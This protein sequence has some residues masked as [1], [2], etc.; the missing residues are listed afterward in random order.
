MINLRQKERLKKMTHPDFE[1]MQ[2]DMDPVRSE[3]PSTPTTLK[4]HRKYVQSL[5]EFAPDFGV[6]RWGAGIGRIYDV[7]ESTH[8]HIVWIKD[9]SSHGKV[10]D[11][12]S[13]IDY[14]KEIFQYWT[15]APS[16]T[17]DDLID[18]YQIKR[19][20]LLI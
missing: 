15:G 11:I 7:N 8:G 20:E 18:A 19:D 13:S 16:F 2:S 10:R 6:L 4:K 14:N 3:L 17:P 5:R 12:L 9:V 1:W